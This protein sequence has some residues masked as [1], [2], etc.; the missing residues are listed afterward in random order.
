MRMVALLTEGFRIWATELP[1]GGYRPKQD[2]QLSGCI[3]HAVSSVPHHDATNYRPNV[4]H[5]SK[6]SSPAAGERTRSRPVASHLVVVVI[7]GAQTL[8]PVTGKISTAERPR[9]LMTLGTHSYFWRSPSTCWEGSYDREVWQLVLLG[10][11]EEVAFKG[12]RVRLRSSHNGAKSSRM[13]TSGGWTNNLVMSIL[14][15]IGW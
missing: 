7:S 5:T 10:E 13:H 8:T 15:A 1:S 11:E 2:R 4:S 6:T 14:N 9:T 12:E 3:I